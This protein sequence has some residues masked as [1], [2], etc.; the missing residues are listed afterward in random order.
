MDFIPLSKSSSHKPGI[1]RAPRAKICYVC[2]RQTLIAGYDYHVEKCRELFEKREAL[3][4]PKERRKIKD[5]FNNVSN[6]M[7][8]ISI[9]EHNK[10]SQQAFTE[11][12]VS[13]L[14]CGRKFLPEKLEIHNRSCT[15]SN[16]SRR[17]NLSFTT[18]ETANTIGV[19][20]NFSERPRSVR[21]NKY[22]DNANIRNSIDDKFATKVFE[23]SF[24]PAELQQCASCGRTFN[25]IAYSKHIK[26]CDKVFIRQRKPY[27]SSKHRITGTDVED[28][29][30]QSKR[31]TG[32]ISSRGGGGGKSIASRKISKEDLNQQ[33]GNT[34][35]NWRVKSENFRNAMKLARTVARAEQRSKATGIPLHHLMPSTTHDDPIYDT[36][37]ECPTCGRKFSEKAG[38]RHIPQCK[39]IIAKPKRLLAHSGELATSFS[40]SGSNSNTLPVSSLRSSNTNAS[41]HGTSKSIDTRYRR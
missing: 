36:Y 37:I 1:G 12:L 22:S 6:G 41:K 7:K 26:I 19:Q 28:F 11:N 20:D 39:N 14:N 29:V 17:V 25:E 35:N 4:P 38:T 23:P 27:D 40:Y 15:S 31:R 2:G 8:G 21:S 5:P 24:I 30:N 33:C 13:C 10:L 16:P 9:D 18:K 32:V 3:K 34:E